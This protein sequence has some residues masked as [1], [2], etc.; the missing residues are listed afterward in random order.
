MTPIK[1]QK[2]LLK[3]ALMIVLLVAAVVSWGVLVRQGQGELNPS[4]NISPTVSVVNPNPTTMDAKGSNNL[5]V[6]VP[7]V[8]DDSLIDRHVVVN[9][10]EYSYKVGST[11]L[12]KPG[13]NI[14]I[15]FE[16]IGKLPHDL[17]INELGVTTGVIQPGQSISIDVQIPDDAV[18]EYAFYSS[19]GQDRELGME[20]RIVTQGG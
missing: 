16:N 9:A 11:I 3:I 18:F 13:E 17:T 20:G 1:E 6:E 8:L 10:I 15:L 2:L 14:R 19:V 7:P 4:S 12:V 5:S